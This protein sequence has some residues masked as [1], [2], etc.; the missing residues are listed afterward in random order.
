MRFQF[1]TTRLY[2]LWSVTAPLEVTSDMLDE[3]LAAVLK[4]LRL[5]KRLLER[6]AG[7]TARRMWEGP[8]DYVHGAAQ[9]GVKALAEAGVSPD[10]V[11]LLINTSVTR[12]QLEPAV[13]VQIHNTMGLA[14]S[15]TNFDITNACLGFVNG[16]D[17]AATLID[18]GQIDYAVVV[19]GED[20]KMFKNQPSKTC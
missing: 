18:A 9:A 10:A 20:A 2:S 8:E 13:S 19:A 1:T 17:L 7:V 4:R 11:G 14:P 3:R 12:T 16:M 6:V 5:P 15:A